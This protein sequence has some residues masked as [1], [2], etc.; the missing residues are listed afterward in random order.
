MLAPSEKIATGSASAVDR[1]NPA[2]PV[3]VTG[4]EAWLRAGCRAYLRQVFGW[5]G[6]TDVEIILADRGHAGA[7]GETAAEAFGAPVLAATTG[8]SRQAMRNG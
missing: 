4:W 7:N 6:I 2:E 1:T 5:L 3:R 8:S